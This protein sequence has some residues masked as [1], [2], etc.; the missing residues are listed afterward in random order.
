MQPHTDRVAVAVE[1]AG[2]RV[3]AGADG[4]PG[5][6][7]VRHILL[8]LRAGVCLTGVHR[9]PQP[10]ELRRAGDLIGS[11]RR[12]AAAGLRAGGVGQHRGL[13]G[14]RLSRQRQHRG[15]RR[16]IF[17]KVQLGRLLLGQGQLRLVDGV[18]LAGDLVRVGV[19]DVLRIRKR[20]DQRLYGLHRLVILTFALHSGI[21]FDGAAITDLGTVLCFLR[22]G[23][24][25][26]CQCR[27][28]QQRQAQR[29]HKKQACDAFSHV[30]ILLCIVVRFCLCPSDHSGQKSQ[31]F[32]NGI[33][34]WVPTG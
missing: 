18:Q 25:L 20:V 9:V 34:P 32:Q 28:G 33:I 16:V 3:L 19:R 30:C 31:G 17:G 4:G 13:I 15:S 7:H 22:C 26:L 29:Q 27:C 11:L 14:V 1:G 6:I 8:Q 23:T 5:L 2:I 21:F 12:A 24:R 10:D